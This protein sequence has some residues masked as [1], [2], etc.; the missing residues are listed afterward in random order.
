M[1]SQKVEGR[2]AVDL[3]ERRLPSSTLEE[4][5]SMALVNHGPHTV[6]MEERA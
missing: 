3:L 6:R 1:F 5:D 4:S 2:H